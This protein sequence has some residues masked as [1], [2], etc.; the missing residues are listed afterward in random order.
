MEFQ[1]KKNLT[2]Y[3]KRTLMLTVEPKQGAYVLDSLRCAISAT[4]FTSPGES[5]GVQNGHDLDPTYKLTEQC[6]E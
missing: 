4:K 2:K 6:S 3:V 1:W 5:W